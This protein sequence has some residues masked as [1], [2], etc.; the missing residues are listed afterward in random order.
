M[1][2]IF[3][4]AVGSALEKRIE[5]YLTVSCDGFNLSAERGPSMGCLLATFDAEEMIRRAREY[6]LD[7]IALD[8]AV[9]AEAL[10]SLR[11]GRIL[12][13]WSGTVEQAHLFIAAWIQ[14]ARRSRRES[15]DPESLTCYFHVS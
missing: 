9:L 5:L 13:D 2:I 11:E 7:E 6:Y 1:I 10:V 15:I 14:A 12:E 8:K 3:N 4:K